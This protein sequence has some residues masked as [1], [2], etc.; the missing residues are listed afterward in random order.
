[1]WTTNHDQPKHPGP[2]VKVPPSPP[3]TAF[4]AQA[5]APDSQRQFDRA[6][7]AQARRVRN[8]KDAEEEARAALD[9]PTYF[10]Q[11]CAIMVY[12]LR[13][14]T[15]VSARDHLTE[16]IES[17]PQIILPPKPPTT[18]PIHVDMSVFHA[19]NASNDTSA[20]RA[21]AIVCVDVDLMMKCEFDQRAMVVMK[22]A[23]EKMELECEWS[24][25]KDR[26]GSTVGKFV[27][28]PP[29][30]IK[31]DRIP[32]DKKFVRRLVLGLFVR[33]G[34]PAA[35][36]TGIWSVSFGRDHEQYTLRKNDQ[37]SLELGSILKGCF[38]ARSPGVMRGLLEAK[39][40][41]IG[42]WK[43]ILRSPDDYIRPTSFVAVARFALF[44]VHAYNEG[45][46]HDHL[47][48]A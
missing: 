12:G 29:D 32:I 10:Y 13:W 37:G 40:L 43:V 22:Q 45:S 47:R 36:F 41:D 14:S 20:R 8:Q 3:L 1:M 2:S 17:V 18:L 38:G 4:S 34:Q 16:I 21:S 31:I 25:G 27:L 35:L 42:E 5:E 11:S 9:D 19:D 33:L 24:G 46:I 30:N 44:G 26:D 48:S 39:E 15:N 28:V 23:L 6:E 7:E